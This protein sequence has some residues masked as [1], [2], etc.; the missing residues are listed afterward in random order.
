MIT[1]YHFDL[2]AGRL[3][4]TPSVSV[5]KDLKDSNFVPKYNVLER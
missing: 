2:T 5:Y 3:F 1:N 4:S